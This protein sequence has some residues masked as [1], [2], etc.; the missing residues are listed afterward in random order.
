MMFTDPEDRQ[1]EELMR[2]LHRE[3]SRDFQKK[4]LFA[5]VYGASHK[6]RLEMADNA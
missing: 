3:P 1:S 6:K 5:R 2:E 4:Q